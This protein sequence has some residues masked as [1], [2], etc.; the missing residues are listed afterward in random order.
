MKLKKY[1]KKLQKLAKKN[2]EAL[3]YMVVTSGDDEGNNFNA[4]Y[5]DPSI[6]HWSTDGFDVND[7]DE[8]DE[9]FEENAV[10]VN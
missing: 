10:C 8:D 1:I 4:V 5:F 9:D 3:E 2:P 6:G 7:E